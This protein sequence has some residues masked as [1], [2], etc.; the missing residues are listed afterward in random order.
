MKVK[1]RVPPPRRTRRSPE[2]SRDLILAAAEKLFGE[3]GPDRVGLK[4]VAREAGVSHGLV[5]HY[6]GTY[7]A[8][9]EA[10]LA[11]RVQAARTPLVELLTTSKDSDPMAAI[12]EGVAQLTSDKTTL[13]LFTWALIS[14]RLQ[15]TDF[16]P[17]RVQGLKLV[18]DALEQWIPQNRKFKPTRTD[19]EFVV[20][21]TVAMN[22]G[23]ALGKTPLLTATGL[24][25]DAAADDAFR[26]RMREMVM[27][28][29]ATKRP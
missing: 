10:A 15:S 14:G 29:L 1:P 20:M 25:V 8:L 11:R 27:L 13:R 17:A 18:A 26:T 12:F 2:E 5:S 22:F 21:S 7:D 24:A 4:D 16:F 28:F 6:F 19:I 23:W 9:V 3:Q